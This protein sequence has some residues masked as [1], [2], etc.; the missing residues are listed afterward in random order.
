MRNLTMTIIT[1]HTHA[2]KHGLRVALLAAVA[3]NV[4]A[5]T[6]PDPGLPRISAAEVSSGNPLP[7]GVLPN[8][9][10]IEPYSD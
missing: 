8:G 6:A 2:L 5:C 1:G 4:V 10:T 7:E 9:L 3:A